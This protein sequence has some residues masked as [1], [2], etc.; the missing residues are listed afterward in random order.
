MEPPRL[1]TDRLVIRL[2]TERDALSIVEYQERNREHFEPWSPQAPDGFYTE[3]F[4]RERIRQN[5]DEFHCGLSARFFLWDPEDSGKVVGNAS[6]A[7][8][9]RG[10]F[11][12]CY[13]G[14][15]VDAGAEGKGL[16][17][18][19]LQQIIAWGFDEPGLHRIMANYMPHNR[20]SGQLLRRL[21]FTVEGYARDYLKINGRWEDH[22]LT[23][24]T[25][26]R[27]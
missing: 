21:G 23:S 5:L 19:G 3:T 16:M 18:E 14:Y 2:A 11:H 20:R 4:W 10:A 22:I 9:V 26:S 17:R 27:K 8:I 13:L 6:L 15:A 12:A 1:T 7:E 24:L 25:G